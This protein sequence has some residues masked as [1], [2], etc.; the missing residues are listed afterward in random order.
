MT[1]LLR[2]VSTLARLLGRRDHG[3]QQAENVTVNMHESIPS[4][5][6]DLMVALVTGDRPMA[7]TS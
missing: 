4:I 5:R 6:R 1:L 2:R 3:E 7:S